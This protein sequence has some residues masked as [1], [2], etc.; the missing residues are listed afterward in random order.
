MRKF[1]FC[2]VMSYKKKK[3]HFSTIFRIVGGRLIFL[4]N[5][6]SDFLLYLKRLTRESLSKTHKRPEVRIIFTS[7]QNLSSVLHKTK[8]KVCEIADSWYTEVLIYISCLH[9]EDWPQTGFPCCQRLVWCSW[10]YINFCPH[11][12]PTGKLLFSW[13][14]FA[15]TILKSPYLKIEDVSR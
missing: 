13:F 4:L 8:S 11:I 7:C 5:L 9:A 1:C 12:Y 14:S 15:A 6:V 10:S 3:S 2:C